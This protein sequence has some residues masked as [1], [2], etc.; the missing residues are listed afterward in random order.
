M[1]SPRPLFLAALAVLAVVSPLRAD[2]AGWIFSWSPTGGAVSADVQVGQ[3][4]AT[5]TV[6]LS[7]ETLQNAFGNSFVVAS[8]I[9]L[10]STANPNNPAM[11][12]SNGSYQLN[13]FLKDATSGQSTTLSFTGKLSGTF[14]AL[15]ANLSNVFQAP[16][17]ESVV[18]GANTFT[19]TLDSYVPPGPP[20]STS[21]GAIG[22]YVSVA[23][24]GGNGH[25]TSTSPEPSSLLLCG[26]GAAG[27]ALNGWRR[28]WTARVRKRGDKRLLSRVV[29]ALVVC[30]AITAPTRAGL[31]EW[32]Y[33]T[34]PTTPTVT[35]DGGLS[36]GYVQLQ[37][38]SLPLVAGSSNIVLASL[39]AF[40]TVDHNSP[41]S[42]TNQPWAVNVTITDAASH[43]SATLTF[44][45]TFSG[46]LS[47]QSSLI[48]NSFN[49]PTSQTVVLGGNTYI[50]TANSYVPP[51]VPNALN[52]G[53]I[54]ASVSVSGT[55]SGSTTPE[56]SS[57]LLCGLGA[58][59]CA[60]V[61]RRR[62][63]RRRLA[64]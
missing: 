13:M 51:S 1:K 57:L 12:S 6:T 30:L 25:I 45:G 26:L 19:V 4:T 10:S 20:G 37:G 3:P 5:G 39:S 23:N 2:P 63:S 38:S 59:G 44:S 18:L 27:F 50:V 62:R 8:N 24:T 21:P 58:T 48:N 61:G 28:R 29:L 15:S 60:A 54:G 22:A 31:V 55:S 35:A 53:G 42:F 9:T 33:S 43:Q 16:V 17:T 36:D 40:S 47:S 41:A 34:T 46:T 7:S 32:S 64:V 49:S 11:L 14:S 52:T 56:P